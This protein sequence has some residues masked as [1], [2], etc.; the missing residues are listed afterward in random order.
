MRKDIEYTVINSAQWVWGI[1]AENM[2]MKRIPREIEEKYD[3]EEEE[4]EEEEVEEDG[5]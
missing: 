3:K 5:R 1:V 4:V 2:N